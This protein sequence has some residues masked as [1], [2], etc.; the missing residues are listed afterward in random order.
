MKCENT[1][2]LISGGGPTG[3]DPVVRVRHGNACC[4]RAVARRDLVSAKT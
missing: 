3:L 2:V 1:D 4:A